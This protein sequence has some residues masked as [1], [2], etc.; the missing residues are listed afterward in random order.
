MDDWINGFI[1]ALP[2]LYSFATGP[3][4]P[5]WA[6]PATLIV[7]MAALGHFLHWISGGDGDGH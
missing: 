4:F 2:G 3:V 5:F 6:I 7:V 1:S